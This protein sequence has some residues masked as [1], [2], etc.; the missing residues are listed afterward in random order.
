MGEVGKGLHD[1]EQARIVSI[2]GE[3]DLANADRLLDVEGP[4]VIQIEV[5]PVARQ[6]VG[7]QIDLHGLEL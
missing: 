7:V 1:G 3:F 2:C 4:R 6:N 5:R